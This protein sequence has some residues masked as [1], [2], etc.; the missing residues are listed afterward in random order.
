MPIGNTLEFVDQVSQLLFDAYTIIIAKKQI[1][2]TQKFVF[3]CVI[4]NELYFEI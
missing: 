3:F 4:G 1:F 2:E